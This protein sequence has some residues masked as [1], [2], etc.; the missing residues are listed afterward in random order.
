M[1]RI[2]GARFRTALLPLVA[3]VWVLAAHGRTAAAAEDLR[4]AGADAAS[5]APYLSA[6]VALVRARDTR[7]VTRNI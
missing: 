6:G 2:D 4:A 1:H 3:V 7:F 5:Y